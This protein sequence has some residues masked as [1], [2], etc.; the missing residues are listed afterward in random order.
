MLFQ[1]AQVLLA[2]DDLALL[3]PYKERSEAAKLRAQICVNER[4]EA[5]ARK[6]RSTCS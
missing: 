6:M 3:K 1:Q 4:A 5:A 2:L